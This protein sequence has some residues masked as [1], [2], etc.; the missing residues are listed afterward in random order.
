M[1]T[2]LFAEKE[3]KADRAV[4]EKIDDASPSESDNARPSKFF[5]SPVC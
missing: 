3:M 1:A 4:I 2:V 5:S